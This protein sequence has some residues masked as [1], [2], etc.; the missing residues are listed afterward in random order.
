MK[1]Y[2]GDTWSPPQSVELIADIGQIAYNPAREITTSLKPRLVGGQDK[3][4]WLTDETPTAGFD[5]LDGVKFEN[6]GAWAKGRQDSLQGVFF[7][8]IALGTEIEAPVAVK[9]Y[10]TS[11]NAGAHEAA[12]LLHLEG[13]GLRVYSLLGMAWSQEQGFAM[14][15]SFEEESRSLD[16]VNWSKKLEQPLGKHLT[17]LEA[18]EQVGHS[19]GVMHGNGVTHGDAQIKNFAVNGKDIVLMDLTTARSMVSEDGS[20]DEVN[21]QSGMYKDTSRVIESLQ[22][23]HF[24]PDA[25]PEEWDS[26]YSN[27]IATAYLAGL[28]RAGDSMKD[29]GVD[30][31]TMSSQMIHD[32][33]SRFVDL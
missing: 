20:V 4:I 7:G 2:N 22:A 26:F 33:R 21:L 6:V 10:Q 1:A 18:I 29:R 32:I 25:T 27:V 3:L 13:M 31:R 9:P 28:F 24:L 17:N 30:L 8:R 19:L 23:K 15:T 16:N 11:F 12:M 5:T 14:I